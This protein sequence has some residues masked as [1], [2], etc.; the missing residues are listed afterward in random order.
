MRSNNGVMNG[1][2]LEKRWITD[3]LVNKKPQGTLKQDSNKFKLFY[4]HPAKL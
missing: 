3:S 1:I 2:D 4:D